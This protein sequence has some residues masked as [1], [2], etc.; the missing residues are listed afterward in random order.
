MGDPEIVTGS[1]SQ[2]Q[3][4]TVTVDEVPRGSQR[5]LASQRRGGGSVSVQKPATEPS[6]ATRR[7]V[8]GRRLTSLELGSGALESVFEVL[9]L[10][11]PDEALDDALIA[12]DDE[13]R[14]RAYLVL[15]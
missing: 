6:D 8:E 7:W 1:G 15:V 11:D 4:I 12:F 10:C 13:R 3:L 14:Q 5:R 2:R 9:A